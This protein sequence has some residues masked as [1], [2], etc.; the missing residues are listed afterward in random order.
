MFKIQEINHAVLVLIKPREEH[1]GLLVESD[2]PM[3]F[4]HVLQVFLRDLVE[5]LQVQKLESL[6]EVEMRSL[7]QL[8]F[9][10]LYVVFYL[11]YS[12]K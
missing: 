11:N 9:H 4:E 6:G 7:V 8:Q 10:L 5:A 12:L 3:H 1:I 2:E